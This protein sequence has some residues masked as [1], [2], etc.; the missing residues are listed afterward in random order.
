MRQSKALLFAGLVVFL[1]AVR[2]VAAATIAYMDPAD[3]GNQIW[4]GSLGQD[5]TVNSPITVTELGVFDSGQTG[6]IGGTLEVAIFSSSGTQE[7]PTVTF[8][9]T[10]G[11]LVGGDLF[12]SLATPITL[13]PG[14]YSVTTAGWDANILNGN[15]NCVGNPACGTTG[16]PFTP[17]TLN[18][19]GGAITF[20]GVGFLSGGGLQYLGPI[21]PYPPTEFNAG[22]FQFTTVPEPGMMLELA[23]GVLLILVPRLTRQ[24]VR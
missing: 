21:A 4:N 24:T 23:L 11:T 9:G 8:S 5:F 6:T 2:P 22:S 19:G 20:T 17:P 16:G 14:N 18:T 12:L 3:V 15:M 10:T 7:T 1:L 13:A